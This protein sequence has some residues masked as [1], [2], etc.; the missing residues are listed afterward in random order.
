MQALK[1]LFITT[2]AVVCIHA[3][4]PPDILA[5]P[6]QADSPF[7]GWDALRGNVVIIDFWG[8]WCAP[9]LPA[10][11]KLRNLEA[12]FS[13]R[14]IS[15]IT[16]ARDEPEQVK[17]F[18]DDHGLNFATYAEDDS[19]TFQAWGVQS[20]PSAGI[21]LSDGTLLG[22]TSSENIT[23]DLLEKLLTGERPHLPS[24]QRDASLEWDRSEVQW[25][26]GVKPDFLVVIKPTT[27]GTGGYLYK[28]GSN[29]ISGDGVDLINLI[30]AAW[31]TDLTHLDLRIANVSKDQYR[32]AVIVP[33]GRETT[34]LTSLQDAIQHRFS[35]NVSWREQERDVLVLKSAKQMDASSSQELFTFMRGKITLRAQPMAR[36]ATMLPNFMRQVVVDETGLEGRYDLTLSYRSDNPQVLIDELSTKYGLTLQPA[37]RKVRMLTVEPVRTRE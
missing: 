6:L 5:P 2:V 22:V 20:V 3:Q 28:P 18:F 12:K 23:A 1:A 19:R 17:D 30:T 26:D 15:F 7:P 10:L 27:S 34:L 11:E 9:C 33:A 13:G 16:V 37:R 32:F 29:R 31:Q 21:V 25:L 24:F 8:T 35:L 36:V 4:K 14:P